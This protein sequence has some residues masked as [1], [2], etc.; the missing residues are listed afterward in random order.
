MNLCETEISLYE[1]IKSVNSETNNKPPG[2]DGL[3]AEFYKHSSNEL[4]PVLLDVYDS[5]GKFDTMG[6]TYRGI[7]S[8]IRA[9]SRTNYFRKI[10]GLPK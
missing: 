3:K 9:L 4:A 2:N 7:I 5:W 10:G 1:I 6:V 8:A